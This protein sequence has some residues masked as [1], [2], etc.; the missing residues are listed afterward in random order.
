MYM[1]YTAWKIYAGGNY[2]DES[3]VALEPNNYIRLTL[4]QKNE[5]ITQSGTH[6][7]IVPQPGLAVENKINTTAYMP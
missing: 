2:V 4:S 3:G 5:L 6:L 1:N 7:I